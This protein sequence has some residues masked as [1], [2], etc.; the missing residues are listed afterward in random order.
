MDQTQQNQLVP[1]SKT[2]LELQMF[3]KVD[4]FLYFFNETAY[5]FPQHILIVTLTVSVRPFH[6]QIICFRN[7]GNRILR[8]LLQRRSIAFTRV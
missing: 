1:V 6:F 4:V 7:N 8:V 2:A 5:F 3:H